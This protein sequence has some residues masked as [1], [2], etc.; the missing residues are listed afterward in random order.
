[1]QLLNLWPDKLEETG[2]VAPKVTLQ[3]CLHKYIGQYC[4]PEWFCQHCKEF[5]QAT[6]ATAIGELPPSLMIHLSRFELNRCARHTTTAHGTRH[7]A[8]AA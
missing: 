5:K 4:I 6:K 7:T 2:G 3:D 1:M 8:H